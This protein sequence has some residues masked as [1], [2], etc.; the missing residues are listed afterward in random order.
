M[1]FPET[2]EA[3][4]AAGYTFDNGA[5]CHGCG[6]AIEWWITPRGKKMPMDVDADGNCE[7][8]FGTCPNAKQFRSK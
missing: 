5:N 6:Q 4:K 8:H 1:P 2:I 7:S 3:L